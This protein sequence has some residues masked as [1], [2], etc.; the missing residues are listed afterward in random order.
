MKSLR[1]TLPLMALAAFASAC[2]EEQGAMFISGAL[3]ISPDTQCI[4]RPNA[5][6]AGF[7]LASGVLDLGQ[8]GTVAGDYTLALEVTTNLPAAFTTQDVTRSRQEQPNY[9]NYGNADTNVINFQYAEVY[10]TDESGDPVPQLPTSDPSGIR[11]T[12]VGGSLYNE[13]TG[14]NAKAAI[15]VPL[16]T[17]IEAQRLANIA[18][19]QP[20]VGNPDARATI[21][22]HV[23]VVGRT[24]GGGTVRTPAFVFPLEICRNCLLAAGADA[25]GN[26]PAGTVLTPLK[27]GDDYCQV[28]QDYVSAACL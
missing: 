18:L 26:C 5:G 17:G 21:V 15:F 1:S 3:P 20:L 10:F 13:Q 14:L 24:T 2:V 25:N 7:Y 4:A 23:R 11:E 9:P 12:A 8:D 22:G 6:A 19:T 27:Q 28:G 16:L